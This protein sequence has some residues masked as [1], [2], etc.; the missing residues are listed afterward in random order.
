M[1][2][3]SVSYQHG[4]ST[5]KLHLKRYE[6]SVTTGLISKKEGWEFT[7]EA[8]VEL[9]KDETVLVKKAHLGNYL[10]YTYTP[11]EF[12]IEY[13]M[14]DLFKPEGWSRSGNDLIEIN[15]AEKKIK[16]ACGVIGATL[17][18]V[19]DDIEKEEVIEY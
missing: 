13:R 4:G 19:A 18:T 1:L 14:S 16:D 17:K 10:F 2:A 6:K 5:M 15:G 3:S 9:S 12:E 7:I 11:N 8:R